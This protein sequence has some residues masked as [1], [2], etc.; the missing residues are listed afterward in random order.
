MGGKQNPDGER[1]NWFGFALKGLLF[2]SPKLKLVA[3]SLQPCLYG[4]DTL[5]IND[6]PSG[7]E[8]FNSDQQIC[9]SPQETKA[10]FKTEPLITHEKIQVVEHT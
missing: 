3:F 9:V 8:K 5:M 10:F 4:A 7:S 6:V 2:F 1:E